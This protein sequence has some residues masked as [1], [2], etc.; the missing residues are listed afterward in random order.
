MT[1]MAIIT[2]VM[3]FRLNNHMEITSQI[4]AGAEYFAFGRVPEYFAFG[5]VPGTIK[6][7][8]HFLDFIV[9]YR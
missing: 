4:L 2:I 1:G 9:L 6:D 7:I 3:L 8:T 5:R